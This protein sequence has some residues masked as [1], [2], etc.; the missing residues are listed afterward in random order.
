MPSID[1]ANTS[2]IPGATRDIPGG[3]ARAWSIYWVGLQGPQ[4]RCISVW[5]RENVLGKLRQHPASRQHESA[6][7]LGG[8]T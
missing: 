2:V 1:I 7:N 5:V 6:S 3:H 4:A 8:V